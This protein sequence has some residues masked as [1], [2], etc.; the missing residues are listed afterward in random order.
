MK[1][2]LATFAEPWRKFPRIVMF[3]VACGVVGAA[4][5]TFLQVQFPPEVAVP[6]EPA[7]IENVPNL[8]TDS[9]IE[10]KKAPPEEIELERILELRK[11]V[12]SMQRENEFL[13]DLNLIL[14]ILVAL[15]ASGWFLAARLISR[16]R[17]DK[18]SDAAKSNSR[19]QESLR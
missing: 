1:T 2:I 14:G 10:F 19:V 7:P 4:L 8:R 12:E 16:Y 6:P 15:T 17:L 13:M 9:P 3:Y 18:A 11:Q 5:L